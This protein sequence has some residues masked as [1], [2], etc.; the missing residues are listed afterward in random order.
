MQVLLSSKRVIVNPLVFTNL[1]KRRPFF[2]Y[3]LIHP[4]TVDCV[5]YVDYALYTR[6]RAPR[7]TSTKAEITNRIPAWTFDDLHARADE[8]DLQP[9][10]REMWTFSSALRWLTRH[11]PGLFWDV[12]ICRRSHS[13]ACLGY[14]GWLQGF[15]PRPGLTVGWESAKTL[16]DYFTGFTGVA[17]ARRDLHTNQ[18]MVITSILLQHT[19]QR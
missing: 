19:R 16:H 15:Q 9:L 4:D 7:N 18:K 12:T 3:R 11:A 2:Y 6:T 14:S 1:A 10:N 5:D 13:L 17:G 8:S